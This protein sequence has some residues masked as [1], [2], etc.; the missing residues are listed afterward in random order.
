MNR[1]YARWEWSR[2]TAGK[3]VAVAD[4]FFVFKSRGIGWTGYDMARGEYGHR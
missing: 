1:E 2:S 4:P 3:L